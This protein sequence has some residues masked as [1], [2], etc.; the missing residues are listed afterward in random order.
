MYV[1]QLVWGE[2][3]NFPDADTAFVYV[4]RKAGGDVLFHIINISMLFSLMGAGIGSMLGAGRLLYGMGREDAIPRKFFGVIEAK[5]FV[6][7][8]N[9]LFIG[10]T[11]LAGVFILNFQ[12]AAEMLNFGGFYRFHGC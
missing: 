12:L 3:G 2:W 6:P 5:R 10:A 8:N 11:T 4:A 7:R 1:S 9:V